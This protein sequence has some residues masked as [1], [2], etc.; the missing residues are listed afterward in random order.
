MQSALY[1]SITAAGL[2][3]QVRPSLSQAD[4]TSELRLVIALPP[5]QGLANLANAAPETQFLAVGIPITA[6]SNLSVIISGEARPDQQGFLAGV[7]AAM[8]TPDWRVG[9][10]AVAKTD[11]VAESAAGKAA[12][13]GFFN[14]ATYFCGLCLQAYPPFYDYPLSIELKTEASSAEW[15]IAA[16]YMVD[17]LAQT[18]YVVPGAGDKAMLETLVQS[19]VN[20]ISEGPPAEELRSHWVAS[21]RFA[22][23]LPFVLDLVPDLL[24]GKGG[25]NISVPLIITDVNAD[26]FSPGRQR[27][28]EEVM[29]DLLAG[30]VDT[31][32]D[33]LTG[34]LK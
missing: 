20:V 7:I 26:L 34:E 9:V 6:T 11:G 13:N 32:V 21:L 28:A 30:F 29:G 1:D 8:I 15:Q 22:D 2:R 12:E 4:L 5:D 14:G 19:K 33:P 24:N 18:V 17:H 16:N 27:L 10:I 31:G 3:W 23:T 25:F